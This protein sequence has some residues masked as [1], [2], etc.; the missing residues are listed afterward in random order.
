[1]TKAILNNNYRNLIGNSTKCSILVFLFVALFNLSV[2]S[3][4]K[5]GLITSN[6][7]GIHSSQINP[8]LTANSK[9]FF[10]FNLLST[11][12]F[13]ENN[14]LFIHK[15]DY[16][17]GDFLSLTP[18]FPES[19]EPGTG[20]DYTLNQEPVEAYQQT[21]IM[22]PSLSYSLGRQ[23][24]GVFT[25]IRQIASVNDL[26]RDIA[27]LMY[28]GLEVDTLYG[29]EQ[30]HGAFDIST[31]GW[32]ELGGNYAYTFIK[33]RQNVFSFGV[34]IKVL[35]GYAGLSANAR[36]VDYSLVVE[37]SLSIANLDADVG[38]S[39]PIDFETNDYPA[40]GATFKGKGLAAD[41]GFSYVR[42]KEMQLRAD[43]QRY[44]E[45]EHDDYIFRLGVSMLDLGKI[46]YNEN[47]QQNTYDNVSANLGRVDT[48]GFGSVNDLTK[49]FSAYFYNGDSTASLVANSFQLGLPTRLSVQADYQY[50]PNWYLNTTFVLPVKMAENQLRR[51]SQAILSLRYETSKVEVNMPLS[52][53]NFGKPRLG[54]FVRFYYFSIGTDKLG[55]LFSF[56]DFTGLDLYFSAK[57]FLNKGR[58]AVYKPSSDC[59]HL[60]F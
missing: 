41:L 1:L 8:A 21:E 59:K 36:S 30:K 56:N 42:K 27:I 32:W 47:A 6:F 23:S 13:L 37:D 15:E 49:T 24:V 12:I 7:G 2:S 3:Q 9:V 34:N 44:C 25:N 35:F 46:T 16:R 26:P 55:G 20:V 17:F 29:V 51:P 28:E 39:A 4:E 57:F 18:Q 5:I 19:G 38:F 53:Y 43:P 45:Y 60:A 58:C 40:S 10:D 54:L 22:G 50:Y 14:F 31:M 52:F 11:D 48:L 33:Q